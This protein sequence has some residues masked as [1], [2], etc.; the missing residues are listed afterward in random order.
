MRRAELKNPRWF[1]GKARERVGD[2]EI[3][4]LT[5]FFA[6]EWWPDEPMQQWIIPGTVKEFEGGI[7]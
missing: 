2:T 5:V 3:D 4:Y 1:F 7:A 6:N